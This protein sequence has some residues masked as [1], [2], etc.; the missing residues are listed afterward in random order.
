MPH[1]PVDQAVARLAR[2]MT[3]WKSVEIVSHYET[4]NHQPRQNHPATFRQVEHYIETNHGQ[5]KADSRS[6]TPGLPEARRE[7]YCD[8]SRCADVWYSG[9]R[10]GSVTIS[11]AFLLERVIG[12]TQRPR[13]LTYFYVGK[14]PLYEALPKGRHLGQ[15]TV[16]GRPCDVYMFPNIRWGVN[17]THHFVYDLDAA[18]SVPLRVRAFAGPV[19]ANPADSAAVDWAWTAQTL[20]EVRGGYH[21]PLRSEYVS[22]TRP[23]AAGDPALLS[24]SGQVK[25]ETIRYNA[26]FPA[27]TF[28]PVIEKGTPVTDFIKK[29]HSPPPSAAASQPAAQEPVTATTAGPLQPPKG[30]EGHAADGGLILGLAAIATGVFLRVR[31]T[32]RPRSD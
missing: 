1:T 8:G 3:S 9:D 13:P 19:E 10:Q 26:S 27:S 31:Q 11:R 14:I 28:W 24:F 12:S 7:G 6:I 4:V 30:W 16:A 18:T 25:V 23:K 22:Y 32:T 5:R 20:D 21:M 2:E 17:G 15:S 29:T